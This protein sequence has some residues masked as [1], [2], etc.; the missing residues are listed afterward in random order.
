M[1][2]R[3]KTRKTCKRACSR[4]VRGGNYP[5]VPYN[6]RKSPKSHAWKGIGNWFKKQA[7]PWLRSRVPKAHKY[8]KDNKS[9]STGLRKFGETNHDLP[10]NLNTYLPHLADGAEMFGYGR[11]RK[12]RKTIRRRGGSLGRTGGSLNRTGGV[13]RRRR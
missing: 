3:R 7:I 13:R 11:K 1:P 2:A 12:G 4:R 8:L 10:F 5:M 6:G 9:I